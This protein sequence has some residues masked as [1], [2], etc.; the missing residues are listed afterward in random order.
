MRGLK[1]ALKK[2]PLIRK[3]ADYIYIKLIYKAPQPFDSA[4]IWINKF[5]N[6]EKLN[7]VQVGSN[8][9]IMGDPIY[10][11]IQ[12][13]KSWNVLF[14]E[15][16]PYLFEKLKNNYTSESRFSFENVAINDGSSQ[17]FYSVKEEAK[18][19]IRN[20]PYWYDQLGSFNRDNIV[21]QLNGILEPYIEETLLDGMTL[22]DVLEKNRINSMSLFH[23]D[24]E[25]YDWKILSQ[26]NLKKYCP[27]IILYEYKHLLR[28]ELKASIN[29]LKDTYFIFKL[30][31]DFLCLKKEL[32]K[33]EH[34]IGL[35]GELINAN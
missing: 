22:K 17:I 2:I 6:D 10:N 29:F 15:P 7:I 35:R 11:L 4:S 19:Q 12:K 28:F 25:G 33:K 20:L 18:L 30:G 9:G 13:N 27:T 31:G 32:I 8:D 14:I 16:V 3:L 5:L 23:I 26:L 24:T 1:E 21:K 34:L